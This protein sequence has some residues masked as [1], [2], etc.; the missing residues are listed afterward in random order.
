MSIVDEPD[1]Y[2]LWRE[3]RR[4]CPVGKVADG[5]TRE[6]WWVTQYADVERVLRDGD[7]FSS[8][9]NLETMG[10]VMGTTLVAMDGAEH[11]RYR[12]LVARAFRPSAVERWGE[13]LI[14]PTTVSLLERIAR[15]T[16]RRADLVADLT[17]RYPVQIIAA[18]L[19]VPV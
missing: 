18:I 5:D 7:T 2:A 17:H 11:R 1:P 14:R 9:I 19:G 15:R 6:I 3:A 4:A 16:D 13:E 12:D 10:P 8:R